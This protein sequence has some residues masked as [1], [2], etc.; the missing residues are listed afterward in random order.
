MATNAGDQLLALLRRELID[1]LHHA[2]SQ[3]VGDLG[4]LEADPAFNA[5]AFAGRVLAPIDTT[6][7]VLVALD[8]MLSGEQDGV[9]ARLRGWRDETADGGPLGVAYVVKTGG[10]QV[11]ALSV[12]PESGVRLVL[13]AAGFTAAQD[14]RLSLGGGFALTLSG[15][16]NE[17]EVVFFPDRAPEATKL[18]SGDRIQVDLDAGG[19][20]KLVGVE[21]GPSVLLGAVSIGGW[22]G[23]TSANEIDRGGH[24]ALHGGRVELAPGLVK[25][26]IPVNLTFP[27]DLELR[28]APDVGVLLAGSPGLNTRLTGS[29]S[30]GWLDLD[31]GIIDAVDAPALDLS[32]TTSLDRAIPATPINAQIDGIGM[33]VP[34]AL[35]LGRPVFPDL[36][37]IGIVEPHGVAIGIDLPVLSGSGMLARLDG[38][39]LAGALA[40]EIPPMSA[41]A[42][43][44]LTPAQKNTPLSFLVIMG[45]TFPP[46]G[47]QVGFGFAISGI[48]GVVG[49]NRRIDRA[50]LL[51]AVTD[52]T[53]AQLL[54]PSDPANAGT[55]AISALPAVFPPARGSVIAGPMLQLSWG[56]RI[57]TLSV[58]VLVEAAKQVRL[59]ILGKVVVALPDPEAPLVFLQA[60]FAGFI[61][62]AEPSAMFVASLT[63]SHIVGAPLS[64]DMLLLTRGGADPT[65]VLSA[66][67]FHPSFPV[68]RGVPAIARMSMDL[69]PAPWIDMRCENYFA[70]T[71]N[72]LQVGA[73]LDLGAEVAGCG[74]RGWLAFDALVQYS[75]FRFVADMSGGIAL[76]A[77]GRTLVGIALA[78]HLEGPAPYLARGRGSI[79]LFFFDVCFDFEIGW[80]APPRQL[81]ASF[82][83]GAELRAALQDRTAWRLRG[84]APQ[85]LMLTGPAQEALTDSAMV[86]PYGAISV[87]QERVPLGI[88]IQRFNG[89][90][91]DPQRWDIATGQFADGEPATLNAVRAQFAPGQFLTAGSDDAALTAP[92]FLPL[93]AGTELFPAAAA[94]AQARDVNLE[95]EEHLIARNIRM[96]A[97]VG[98]FVIDI[99]RLYML[100]T[101]MKVN[102]SG[103]WAVTKDVVT[104]DPVAPVAAAF[105][106]SM[107]TDTNLAA[108]TGLEMAQVVE[109]N[110]GLMTVEAWEVAG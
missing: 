97:P 98:P 17:L 3:I 99:H 22:V 19:P 43:G 89:V 12:V 75:P 88:E 91:V 60:T 67:G 24:I 65:L 90:P 79:D 45:A 27:I 31:I 104:V 68:P 10:P 110:A 14:V 11:V 30:G 49:V 57:V 20:G 53:A 100:L 94:G 82:D 69:C 32:F 59:T 80:G 105:S 55:A 9:Q 72:T 74:L 41:A 71:S 78:L 84:T 26:L 109:R 107:A 73:R 46:P 108:A 36:A 70:L 15:A 61:D 21:G 2:V 81:D 87:R 64:G 102:D 50:A 77:F 5:T 42:F 62:P 29:D 44:L 18:G 103:W 16:V 85:G 92:A 51:R 66:G 33:H 96:P 47:V 38:G 56:G 39:D 23:G 86:D 8:T 1:G 95:W 40:V 37:A 93:T 7:P 106:W 28:S 63:G 4:A 52:G 35:K 48:G 25:S 58:A 13:R 101:A 34:I 54:F 6:N 76:R 83:V